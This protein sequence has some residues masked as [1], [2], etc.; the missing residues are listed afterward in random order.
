M[1]IKPGGKKRDL[2]DVG[3]GLMKAMFF[4]FLLAYTNISLDITDKTR[5][6]LWQA[7]LLLLLLHHRAALIFI[8]FFSL[9][10]VCLKINYFSHP[11]LQDSLS[12]CWHLWPS[13]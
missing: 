6:N 8:I 4:P 11:Y 9:M 2:C 5:R 3:K 1:I 10:N 12:D 7:T 13:P